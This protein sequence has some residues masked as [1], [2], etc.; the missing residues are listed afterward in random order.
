MAMAGWNP[1][2]RISSLSP[3]L[4]LGDVSDK[5]GT[6]QVW[7]R[8]TIWGSLWNQIELC[9]FTLICGYLKAP[10]GSYHDFCRPITGVPSP[11]APQKTCWDKISYCNSHW[12]R[13]LFFLKSWIFS[14][15]HPVTPWHPMER[16]MESGS[17]KERPGR[18][19]MMIRTGETWRNMDCNGWRF[20]VFGEEKN[21][22]LDLSM[23]LCPKKAASLYSS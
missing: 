16:R 18:K 8:K 23:F 7:S 11:S 13:L 19:M 15:A 21:I 12:L 17:C 4:E 6:W 9:F 10:K 5:P 1:K 20:L 3:R 14:T 2:M 22:P